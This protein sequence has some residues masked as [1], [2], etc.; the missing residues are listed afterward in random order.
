M[1]RGRKRKPQHLKLI[2]GTDRPDRAPKRPPKFSG[3]LS[4][5]SWLGTLGKVEWKRIVRQA[6]DGLFTSADRQLLAQYCQ[7]CARL[8]E[9]EKIVT[10]QGY[11]FQTEKGYVCQRPEA[12]MLRSLQQLQVRICEQLGFSPTSR[13]RI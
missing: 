4:P 6:P 8:A 9:L 3:K 12:S 10:D 2:E 7:N 11:T 5:P 1:P 13:A